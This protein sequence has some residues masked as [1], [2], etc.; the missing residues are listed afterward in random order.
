MLAQME[1]G[2]QFLMLQIDKKITSNDLS[3]LIFKDR[4]A[5][6]TLDQTL[7]FDLEKKNISSE[8]LGTWIKYH[9][10]N[11][12]NNK[13]VLFE[14]KGVIVPHKLFDETNKNLYLSLSDNDLKS[15]IIETKLLQS[16]DQ[17]FV[18]SYSVDWKL[19]LKNLVADIETTHFAAELIPFLSKISNQNLKKSI[20]IHLRKNYF[21][22]FI[23]QGSQLLLFNSFPHQDEEEFLYYLFFVLEQFYLKQNQF[24]AIFLGKFLEYQKYYS[25][26]QEFHTH[27]NFTYPENLE[28]DSNHPAPF[29]NYFFDYENNI[30]KV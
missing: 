10:I 30:R 3:I 1:I 18:F 5:F 13:C 25:A 27:T 6:C 14:S 23:Y 8:N 21:D 20:Y 2:Q 9:N 17:V 4:I 29:F 12:K 19:I 22:L 15:K 16:N 7:Y 11:K 28:I 24:V 26:F